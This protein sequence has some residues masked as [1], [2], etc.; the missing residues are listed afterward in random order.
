[1]KVQVYSLQTCL[2]TKQLS[3]N[4]EMYYYKTMHTLNFS[5]LHLLGNFSRFIRHYIILS[6]PNHT[7]YTV[8]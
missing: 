3:L 2:F 8:S 5:M 6:S 4:I 1:M 7:M